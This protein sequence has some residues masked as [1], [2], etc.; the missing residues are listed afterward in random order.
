MTGEYA[1]GDCTGAEKARRVRER[2]DLSRYPVVYAYGDTPED[3][4]LLRLASKRYFRW[5]ELGELTPAAVRAD[6]K[7][8]AFPR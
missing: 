3:Y 6:A 7:H 5:Q 2:Y 1:G 4:E 8:S